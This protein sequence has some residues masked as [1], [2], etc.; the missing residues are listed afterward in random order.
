M[1]RVKTNQER[2]AKKLN[3]AWREEQRFTRAKEIYFKRK[4]AEDQEQPKAEEKKD[5]DGI[6]S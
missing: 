2:E 4:Y 3:R 1:G 6:G 5:G